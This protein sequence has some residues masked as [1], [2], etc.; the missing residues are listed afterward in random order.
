MILDVTFVSLEEARFLPRSLKT[1]MISIL[2][3]GERQQHQLPR[4]TYWRSVL[5][6]HFEDTY[7]EIKLA[8]AGDWPDEPS[9]AEHA[10]FCQG[11]GERVPALSDGR[12]IVEFVMQHRASDEQLHLVVH[13]RAGVSRSGAVAK[14]VSETLCIPRL[15]EGETTTAH[16]NKRLLRLLEKA[17]GMYLRELAGEAASPS[18]GDAPCA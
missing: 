12:R 2:D 9:D 18:R 5:S 16:A 15:N 3:R 10:A 17:Y 7:E 14:W 6:L 13:C 8:S 4:L 1:L 11:G